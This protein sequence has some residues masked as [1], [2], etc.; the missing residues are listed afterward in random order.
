MNADDNI[1]RDVAVSVGK[2][3]GAKHMLV[4]QKAGKTNWI[5][6]VLEGSPDRVRIY[7]KKGGDR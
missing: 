7:K 2:H 1:V 5:E 6:V 3:L 4:A